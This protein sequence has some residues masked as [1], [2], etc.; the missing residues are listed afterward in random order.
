VA[1]RTEGTVER[2]GA[3]VDKARRRELRDAAARVPIDAGVYRITNRVTGT[4]WV[5]STCDL[6]AYRN[7]FEFSQST[8]SPTGFD[9]RARA[10]AERSGV[11]AVE[12]EVLE[13]VTPR[14]DATAD[15]IRADLAVLE[16]VWRAKQ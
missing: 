14:P 6:K 16:E 7:R 5:A 15:E 4:S 1:A 10:E 12:F 3:V 8:R 11:D 13:V 2:E 9:Q